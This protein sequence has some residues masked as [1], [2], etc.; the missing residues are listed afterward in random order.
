MYPTVGHFRAWLD[1][2]SPGD[3]KPR[4]Y[5]DL[6]IVRLPPKVPEAGNRILREPRM[7]GEPEASNKRRPDRC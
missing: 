7:S 5:M 3:S 4:D 2:V 1:S 6:L